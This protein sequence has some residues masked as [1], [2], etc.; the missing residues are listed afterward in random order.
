MLGCV[1]L[2][3]EDERITGAIGKAGFNWGVRI[4]N[5]RGEDV[6]QGE[7]GESIVKG[8]GVRKEYYKNPEKTAETIKKGWLYTGDTAK[9]DNEGFIYLVDRKKKVIILYAGEKIFIQWK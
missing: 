2:P 4:V 5:D 9:M 1:Y 3:A 8:D 7:V 6:A